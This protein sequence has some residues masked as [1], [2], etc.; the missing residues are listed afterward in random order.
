[1][2]IN[3]T[4]FGDLT[5]NPNEIIT[6]SNGLIGFET[7]HHWTLLPN[8]TNSDVAWLQSLSSPQI[9][10][11]VVSPRRHVPDYR[12]HVTRRDLEMLRLRGSDQLYVLTV[13]SRNGTKLTTNLKSPILLNATQRIAV[14]VVSID[15]AALA[16]PIGT[17]VPAGAKDDTDTGRSQAA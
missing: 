2:Q 13:V 4:R 7:H 15:D 6:A 9:A 8:P 1:M 17:I 11:P 12:V 5:I 3:T 10:L 16:W 14:Q